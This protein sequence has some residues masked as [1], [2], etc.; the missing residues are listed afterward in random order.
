MYKIALIFFS[1]GTSPD[2]ILGEGGGKLEK[3]YTPRTALALASA[4][5]QHK[6]ISIMIT[7]VTR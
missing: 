5:A 2:G 4:L 3:L 6:Q 7:I 1:H